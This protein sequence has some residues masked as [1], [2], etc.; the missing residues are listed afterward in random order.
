MTRTLTDKQK[1]FIEYF[2][3]TG[4]ATASCIK[5]GYSKATAE[6]QG[7][8]LKNKLQSEI[9][10]ATKKIL[11]GS[12]PIAVDVL[13]KLVSDP[14]IPPSTRL[15]AVNSLLDRTGYQTTTKFEDITGKK[16]DEELKAELDH[17]LSNMKIVKLTDPSDGGSSLN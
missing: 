5:A 4:N 8:E 14:K 13:T 7:Y 9:E 16:T 1:L 6:Q 17:L 12:V 2:S 3:S 15:Q 11:S 10:T